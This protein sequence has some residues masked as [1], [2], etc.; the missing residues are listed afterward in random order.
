M[1]AAYDDVK[2]KLMNITQAAKLHGVPRSTLSKIMNGKRSI[3]P[4]E[5]TVIT[6]AE[7]RKLEDWI[8]SRSRR[9]FGVTQTELFTTVQ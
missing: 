2:N 8:L 4:A 1:E 5:K 9:G 6:S 3:I 7:E